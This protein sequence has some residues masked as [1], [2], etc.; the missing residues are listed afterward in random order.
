MSDDQPSAS[1]LWLEVLPASLT[2]HPISCSGYS[3]SNQRQGI[4]GTFPDG[5]LCGEDSECDSHHCARLQGSK[6]SFCALKDTTEAA[7]C[8]EESACEGG[9]VCNS[10]GTCVVLADGSICNEDEDC[11]SQVRRVC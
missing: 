11:Q 3:S 4:C 5:A 2:P 8:S 7:L 1:G 10:F 9:A 6:H